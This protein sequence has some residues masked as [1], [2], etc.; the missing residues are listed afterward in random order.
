VL[1]PRRPAANPQA[2]Y[3]ARLI[4][5]RDLVLASGARSPAMPMPD[6]NASSPGAA[7]DAQAG[8]AGARGN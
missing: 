3:L 6:A 2:P 1:T 4:G 7:C 5:G 8:I